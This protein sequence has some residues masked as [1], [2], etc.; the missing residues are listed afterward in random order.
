M[1]IVLFLHRNAF[2]I[3]NLFLEL[4]LLPARKGVLN[5]F[6]LLFHRC[7]DL[8]APLLDF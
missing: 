6:F 8:E 4:P 1:A 7:P 2:L 3:L 5:L